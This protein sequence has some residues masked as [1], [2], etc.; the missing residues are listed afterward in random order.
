MPGTLAHKIIILLTVAA[1]IMACDKPIKEPSVAGSFYPVDE[2][3]LKQAVSNRLASVPSQSPMGSRIVALIAP[4][5]GYDYSGQ[6]AASAYKKI[7]NKKYTTVV[8]IGP[9]HHLGFEGASVYDHGAF[10]TPMG[11]VDIDEDFAHELMNDA[12]NV[13]FF[14]DAFDREHSI[15]VQLP[16]LQT[17]LGNE[18][19]IV[20]ILM[21]IPSD[22]TFRYL[23]DKLVK[24]LSDRDDV[25][26]IASTDLSHYRSY[27]QAVDMDQRT[28]KAI[29]QMSRSEVNR[30]MNTVEKGGEMCGIGAVLITMDV[31]RKLGATRGTLYAYA[32]S[33]DTTGEHDRVVGYAAMGLIADPMTAQDKAEI[34]RIARKSIEERVRTGILPSDM[35]TTNPRLLADG[36]V[37]VTINHKGKLRGCIGHINPFEPLYLSVVHNASNAAVRDLRFTPMTPEEL[38]DI[39]VEVSIL[40][41]MKP[42]RADEV[43]VGMHGLLLVKDHYSGL[44]LPQVPVEKGWNRQE[45]LENL[46]IKAGL[47]PDGWKHNVTLYG[48]TAEVIKEQ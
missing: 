46:S 21:G 47:E 29:E 39:E 23:S 10:E 11:T 16:F 28:I 17:T 45:Y 8:L 37:F 42:I 3:L 32:N 13:R 1:L 26:I 19:K 7:Q 36:A 4:H 9:S 25:L 15:E 5:A 2:S 22:A 20:P 38:D 34:L 18:F 12:N 33:G 35:E 44:L 31:A 41:A 14:P 40:S 48:F 30:L 43:K 24:L 27:E 6:V